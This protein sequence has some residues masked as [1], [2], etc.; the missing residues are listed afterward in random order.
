MIVKVVHVEGEGGPWGDVDHLALGD[1]STAQGTKTLCGKVWSKA[2]RR[3]SL[4]D[5]PER[6]ACFHCG[7]AGQ[8]RIIDSLVAARTLHRFLGPD[9]MPWEQLKR[10]AG[11]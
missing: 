4:K 5:T 9:A 3:E 7:N 8:R 1:P 11:T 6:T 10:L 2:T